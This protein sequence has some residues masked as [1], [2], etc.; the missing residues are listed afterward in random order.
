MDQERRAAIVGLGTLTVLLLAGSVGGAFAGSAGRSMAGWLRRSDELSELLRTGQTS[1][2]EWRSGLN[3]VF[4]RLDLSELLADIDLDR[5]AATIGFARRGVSTLRVRLPY[6]DRPVHLVP[7][8]FAIG[9]GRAIIPHGHANMVSGH[10]LLRGGMHLRTWDQVERNAGGLVVRP[11]RDTI[12]EPG[13][14]SSIGT[15]AENVH[16]LVALS[17]AFTLDLIVTGLDSE[18]DE[19]F[20]IFNLD[21]NRAE[22]LKGDL[23]H[24]PHMPVDQAL[25]VY[26]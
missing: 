14:F 12:I 26:G 25:A 1:V 2:E 9:A 11:R 20:A 24:A 22:H 18:A 10:L 13:A 21:M 4:H 16:W 5:L 17:D 8:L 7:K 6:Q 23:F 19:R 15:G 3:A